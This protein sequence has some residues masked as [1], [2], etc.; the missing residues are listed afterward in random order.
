MQRSRIYRLNPEPQG[1][2]TDTPVIPAPR[3]YAPRARAAT[4]AVL[5]RAAEADDPEPEA[6]LQGLVYGADDEPPRRL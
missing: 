1:P 6:E 2:E 5:Q 4:L 3:L